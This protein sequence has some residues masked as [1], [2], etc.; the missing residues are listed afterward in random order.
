M[1]GEKNELS[2][3]I[4]G[5][6]SQQA[7]TTSRPPSRSPWY[8]RRLIAPLQEPDFKAQIPLKHKN[9][10]P[11]SYNPNL[12]AYRP[13]TVG[14]V[15]T[16][17]TRSSHGK[18]KPHRAFLDLQLRPFASTFSHSF[19]SNQPVPSVHTADT[20]Q[21]SP[22]PAGRAKPAELYELTVVPETLSAQNSTVEVWKIKDSKYF[23][24]SQRW[25]SPLDAVD[26]EHILVEKQLG[27]QKPLGKT[28]L[29]AAV[30]QLAGFLP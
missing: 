18:T 3:L 12:T 24:G 6:S 26:L 2:S 28:K 7:S 4:P 8:L 25:R 21:I 30:E 10:G 14:G 22:A 9:P 16:P 23:F 29:L 17:K 5:N 13:R 27:E 1:G 11:G 20:A 15:I 19:V